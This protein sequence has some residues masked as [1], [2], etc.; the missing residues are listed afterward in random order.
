MS[1]PGLWRKGKGYYSIVSDVLPSDALRG[2]DEVEAYGGYL[3]AES[4]APSNIP[5]IAAAPELRDA[6]QDALRVIEGSYSRQSIAD[7]YWPDLKPV[8][9]KIDAVLAK[10]RDGER[11]VEI[12]NCSDC[13]ACARHAYSDAT[14]P[15][16]FYTECEKH[17]Q[18]GI[19]GAAGFTYVQE[20]TI[21]EAKRRFPN[22][23][24]ERWKEMCDAESEALDATGGLL[25]VS[26]EIYAEMQKTNQEEEIAKLQK[27]PGVTTGAEIKPAP[28]RVC[29][30]CGE[31][32]GKHKKNCRE[33]KREGARGTLHRSRS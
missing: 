20:M 18:P 8:L 32:F 25:A 22:W 2:S 19:Q 31:K 9:E 29:G 28:P 10:V 14:T 4:V 15:G 26:P 13:Q 3:I 5:L 6:L 12:A 24:P 27:I 17:R 30:S 33:G 7:G 23:S 21:E 1:T 16:F 11:Q